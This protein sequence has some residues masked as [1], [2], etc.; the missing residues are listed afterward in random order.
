MG[1]EKYKLVSSSD[2][3]RLN[4][5]KN[6][7]ISPVKIL[8][9]KIP[10]DAKILLHGAA[11]RDLEIKQE[12]RRNRPIK[13]EPIVT[14]EETFSSTTAVDRMPAILNNAKAIALYEHLKHHGIG[15]NE[16][17]EVTIHGHVLPYTNLPMVI[18]GLTNYN[19]GYQPGMQQVLSALPNLPS[20]LMS[21]AVIRKHGQPTSSPQ[22][23]S[24]PVVTRTARRQPPQP[25]PLPPPYQPPIIR[26]KGGKMK[27]KRSRK[28][29]QKGGNLKWI[30]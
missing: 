24:S 3:R 7:D 12:K 8:K 9:R 23:R 18:R 20:N 15:Y 5:E 10:D 28:N 21:S 25:P 30:S 19:I 11:S 26:Q 14:K 13:V 1:Y 4:E 17:G 27:K 16:K 6:M 29:K 22:S 2:F